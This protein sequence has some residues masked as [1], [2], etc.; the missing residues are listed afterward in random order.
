MS[1][2]NPWVMDLAMKRSPSTWSDL[3]CVILFLHTSPLRWNHDSLEG[4]FFL[5]VKVRGSALGGS[6]RLVGSEVPGLETRT[7]RKIQA[8]LGPVAHY[9]IEWPS[10]PPAGVGVE[11]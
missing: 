11:V 2:S 8:V 7:N 5:D 10:V 3:A 1:Q 4:R 6:P 9:F